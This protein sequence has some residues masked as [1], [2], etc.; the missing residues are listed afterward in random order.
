MQT[1]AFS[2]T[3]VAAAVSA[4]LLGAGF[5]APAAQA[6]TP[7]D[8]A[9]GSETFNAGNS[10]YY[11]SENT[12]WNPGHLDLTVVVFPNDPVWDSNLYVELVYQ[13][14]GNLVEYCK[15]GPTSS[16]IHQTVLW[17]SG[18]SGSGGGSSSRLAMQSDGNLV[19]YNASDHASWASGTNNH[20]TDYAVLQTDDNF[21]IYN[22]NGAALWSAR[23]NGKCS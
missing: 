1:R 10:D 8:S 13:G 19:V 7:Q 23:T 15:A 12:C 6:A 14:D 3:A 11:L 16:P 21:V 4:V 9:C 2:R 20:P 22:G 18:T 17:A 5:S